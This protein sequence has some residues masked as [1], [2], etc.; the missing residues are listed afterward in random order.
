M[1]DDKLL[2]TVEAAAF[3]RMHS[4]TLLIMRGEGRGP[5]FLRPTDARH[6]L[7]RQS[8][9]MK[10]LEGAPPETPEQRTARM[11]SYSTGKTRVA[12]ETGLSSVSDAQMAARSDEET[13][14]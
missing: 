4:Q 8:E 7:Y 14:K 5:R 10:W 11:N 2:T 1:S 12:W 13:V 6:Y 9:L 3:C